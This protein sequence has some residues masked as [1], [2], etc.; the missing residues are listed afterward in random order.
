[1]SGASIHDPEPSVTL[2]AKSAG[3]V[4][5][6]DASMKLHSS[7][8]RPVGSTDLTSS[9]RASSSTSTLR[10]DVVLPILSTALSVNRTDRSLRL[11]I[12]SVSTTEA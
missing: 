11:G 4:S 1:M 12:R 6:L 3:S 9:T 8:S 5:L 10:G 7:S 2:Y